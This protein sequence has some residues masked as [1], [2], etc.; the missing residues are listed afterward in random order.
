M[1]ILLIFVKCGINPS[2]LVL[3]KLYAL[4]KSVTHLWLQWV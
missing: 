1:F 2:P 4:G 3:L